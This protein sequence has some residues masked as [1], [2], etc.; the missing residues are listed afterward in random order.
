L[1]KCP[2]CSAPITT[3]HD[4]AGFLHCSACGAKLRVKPPA[5]VAE[6]SARNPSATLPPGTPR[7]KIPRPE[8]VRS[9]LEEILAEIR[10]VRAT[11]EQI[12]G[13]LGGGHQPLEMES[14]SHVLES[15]PPPPVRTRRRKSVLLIDDDPLAR[16]AAGELMRQAEIPVRLASDGGAG[17]AAIAAEKPD[18]IVLELDLKD[19]M[20]GKD[21][22]NMI[23]ATMEWVDIPIIL[24][25]RVAVD[26]QKEARIVHGADEVVPKAA[27]PAVLVTKVISVFRRG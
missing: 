17:L 5:P 18:V 20:A 12:L 3:P 23:K 26:G 21:V 7:P 4:D 13:L 27:G 14:S 2:R 24:Y 11:Q 25:T 22:I 16:E 15:L 1:V 19:P 10:A 6:G 8:E 9:P